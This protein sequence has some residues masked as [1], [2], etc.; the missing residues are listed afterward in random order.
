MFSDEEDDVNAYGS[1]WVLVN[2]G[3]LFKGIM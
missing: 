1:R 2:F 3:F